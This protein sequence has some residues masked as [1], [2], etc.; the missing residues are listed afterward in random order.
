M[1]F[2]KDKK[3][4]FCYII[5]YI[6][7]TI[8]ITG[9]VIV[10]DNTSKFILPIHRIIFSIICILVI[11]S[12][13]AASLVDPGKI[14]HNNNLDSIEYYLN[15][16]EPYLENAKL[17]NKNFKDMLKATIEDMGE[18]ELNISEDDEGEEYDFNY[19]LNSKIND[20]AM[21][22]IGTEYNVMLTRCRKCLVVR[23]PRS[24]HCSSCKAYF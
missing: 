19:D 22:K 8:Q 18:E 12:H 9:V 2:F 11:T 17:L 24:H 20:G 5:V 14:D 13:I 23:L 1:L 21:E 4:L 10:E 6:V 3:S 7:I 16:H 15:E